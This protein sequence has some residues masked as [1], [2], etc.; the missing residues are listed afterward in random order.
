MTRLRKETVLSNFD[1]FFSWNY[2]KLSVT[3][4]LYTFGYDCTILPTTAFANV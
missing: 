1:F 2:L 4:S 3:Q